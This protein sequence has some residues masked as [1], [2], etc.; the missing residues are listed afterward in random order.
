[1]HLKCDPTDHINIFQL[2]FLLLH[3][4]VIWHLCACVMQHHWEAAH[5]WREV[6]ITLTSPS[7]KSY[8]DVLG[9]GVLM[10]THGA[11]QFSL[12]W[13]DICCFFKWTQ[14]KFWMVEEIFH[15][16]RIMPCCLLIPHCSC[17]S[18][19]RFILRT[20]SFNCLLNEGKSSLIRGCLHLGCVCRFGS[21]R[22]QIKTV[23]DVDMGM[24][25]T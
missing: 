5:V 24:K 14:Q 8:K 25:S 22:R 15:D 13:S 10:N 4:P 3:C 11:Q 1:M 19:S 17:A 16:G 12:G 7:E 20:V 2:W 6:T 18:F 21:I 9:V 23:Q